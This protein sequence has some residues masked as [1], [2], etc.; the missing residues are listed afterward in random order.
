LEHKQVQDIYERY[1]KLLVNYSLPLKAGDK[2]LIT[3]SY[4]AE[5]LV[6]A[7]YEESLAV[8]AHPEL[9]IGINGTDRIF[10][11]KASDEQ[12]KYVSPLFEYV[13]KNYD[14]L[15]N[16]RAPFNMKEL[17]SVDAGKKQTVGMAGAE[18]KQRI[19]QRGAAG[20]FNWTLCVFPTDAAAQACGMSRSEYEEFVYS[21]CF[22]YEDDPVGEWK[23][24]AHRQQRIVDF[25]DTKEQIRYVGKD[26]DISFSTKGRTWVNSAGTTNMPSGEVFTTP[27]EDSVNGKIRFSYPGFYFGQEIEDISLEVKDGEVVKWDARKGKELLDKILDIPGAKR[28][29]EAAVG[30]NKGIKKFTKNMLFDEKIGGTI[31]MAVGAAIPQTGGKN[32]CGIHWDMLADMSDGGQIFADGEIIYENGDFII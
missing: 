28:F 16:I 19:L 13:S 7:V 24:L 20:D 21:A 22:L 25:L 6:K 4:L 23:K 17:E 2:F 31:H 29:G 5:D 8:G 30:T 1:A 27:V 32:E 18:V 10:F 9:R 11:D 3:S 26:I 12:L 15:L 14:A